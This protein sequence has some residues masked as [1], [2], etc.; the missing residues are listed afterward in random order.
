MVFHCKYKT[1]KQHRQGSCVHCTRDCANRRTAAG[2]LD[3]RQLISKCRQTDTAKAHRGSVSQCEWQQFCQ[4]LCKHCSKGKAEFVIWRKT[5]R[6]VGRYLWDVP[7]G[8]GW[9]HESAYW[10]ICWKHEGISWGI[11]KSGWLCASE[12]Y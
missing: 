8:Y 7:L 10:K 5:A 2:N 1:S 4:G 9:N 11:N 3:L 6:Q 12:Q